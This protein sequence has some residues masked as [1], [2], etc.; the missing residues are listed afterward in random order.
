MTTTLRC[1]QCS[2][3]DHRRVLLSGKAPAFQAGHTGSIPVTRSIV[4][5]AMKPHKPDYTRVLHAISAPQVY[6][7]T[8]M[9]SHFHLAAETVSMS[10]LSAKRR[11]QRREYAAFLLDEDEALQDETVFGSARTVVGDDAFMVN[12]RRE[13]GRSTSRGRGRRRS[14]GNK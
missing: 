13:D 1:V 4:C 7:R 2:L 8:V 9:S 11:K 12:T 14:L 3:L 5:N 6:H 10:D